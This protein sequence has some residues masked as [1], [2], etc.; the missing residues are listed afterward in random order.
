MTKPKIAKIEIIKDSDII[1]LNDLILDN[2]YIFTIELTSLKGEIFELQKKFFESMLKGNSD[3]RKNNELICNLKRNYWMERLKTTVESRKNFFK[4]FKQEKI[5]KDEEM[6]KEQNKFKKEENENDIKFRNKIIMNSTIC[7]SNNFTKLNNNNSNENS[8]EKSFQKIKSN[9]SYDNSIKDI[10]QKIYEMAMK[11]HPDEKRR[12]K[13]EALKKTKN[14]QNANSNIP[15]KLN[16]NEIKRLEKNKKE[17]NLSD[18]ENKNSADNEDIKWKKKFNL[19]KVP[20]NN[21]PTRNTCSFFKTG[22]PRNKSEF[23]KDMYEPNF[24]SFEQINKDPNLLKKEILNNLLYSQNESCYNFLMNRSFNKFSNRS[25][26]HLYYENNSNNNSKIKKNNYNE[27]KEKETNSNLAHRSMANSNS[28][29]FHEQGNQNLISNTKVELTKD[30]HYTISIEKTNNEKLND[31][32]NESDLIN[33]NHVISNSNF[34]I[35]DKFPKEKKIEKKNSFRAPIYAGI[36]VTKINFGNNLGINNNQG[37][38]KY[39]NAK[40]N[41]SDLN[42]ILNRKNPNRVI[43]NINNKSLLFNESIENNKR[44]QNE[45]NKINETIT[46]NSN[47]NNDLSDQFYSHTNKEKLDYLNK[48]DSMSYFKTFNNFNDISLTSLSRLKI[49]NK[50]LYL[51][52]KGF[53]NDLRPLKNNKKNKVYNH[54]GKLIDF[55]SHPKPDI[56]NKSPSGNYSNILSNRE[57]NEEKLFRFSNSNFKNYEGTTQTK[58]FSRNVLFNG[59]NKNQDSTKYII[60]ALEQERK[61]DDIKKKIYQSF[62]QS[63]FNTD[64][65]EGDLELENNL[66]NSNNSFEDKKIE[67][68]KNN[69]NGINIKNNFHIFNSDKGESKLKSF[70]NITNNYNFPKINLL[71]DDNN[72]YHGSLNKSNT[73]KKGKKKVLG[74]LVLKNTNYNINNTSQL[75]N[76]N[77]F[78]ILNP[79]STYSSKND[80]KNYV[81]QKNFEGELNTIFKNPSII[82]KNKSSFKLYEN[83]SNQKI[84]NNTNTIY[85]KK[86]ENSTNRPSFKNSSTSIDC[87][88]IKSKE[89]NNAQKNCDTKPQSIPNITKNSNVLVKKESNK[90][91]DI[92]EKKKK[93]YLIDELDKITQS[94]KFNDYSKKQNLN[95]IIYNKIF[96]GILDVGNTEKR[97]NDDVYKK[98][99]QFIDY[100]AIDK[101]N[102]IYSKS[103]KKTIGFFSERCS[104]MNMNV[105]P[106]SNMNKNNIGGNLLEKIKNSSCYESNFFSNK[107]LENTKYSNFFSSTN[108]GKFNDSIR[109]RSTSTSRF[110]MADKAKKVFQP[111]KIMTIITGDRDLLNKIDL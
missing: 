37:N 25:L 46:K 63:N 57:N 10:S 90:E 3:I 75:N 21:K 35:T 64:E 74:K 100:L 6:Q 4:T 13:I 43:K 87:L 70:M 66:I 27:V 84:K 86:K 65:D 15:I 111:K 62:S 52:S 51:S 73:N 49:N 88:P 76:L 105:N 41:D 92:V 5:F 56:S 95:R 39:L 78:N 11:N 33:S 28:N 91:I 99:S 59:N 93:M 106:K 14:I 85:F 16:I 79:N 71:E 36:N 67:L 38:Q 23:A 60:N 77:F 102:E 8:K 108:F 110:L 32:I 40:K 7:Y 68:E 94:T 19:I 81:D 53:S 17:N 55:T 83:F 2:K 96:S 42:I 30:V 22:C 45:N 18:S 9:K 1:G 89:N 47:I 101:F 80:T 98:D 61:D 50:N 107:E 104:N 54:I 34:F 31:L 44:I 97:D 72:I 12:L 103:Y 69:K 29:K 82:N 58:N 26:N 48:I 109:F 24:F 20:D